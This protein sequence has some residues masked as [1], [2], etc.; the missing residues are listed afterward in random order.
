MCINR[1]LR[2]IGSCF[3]SSILC[4][5]ASQI[6]EINAQLEVLANSLE[7]ATAELT[8]ALAGNGDATED[9][10]VPPVPTFTTIEDCERA[11][12]PGSCGSGQAIYEQANLDPPADAVGWYM[13]IAFGEM[14]GVLVN[15]YY[16]P[17]T[18]YV[19]HVRYR[20][21]L[22]NTDRYRVLTPATAAHFRGASSAVQQSVMASGQPAR[23]TP[24]ARTGA[25]PTT[26]PGAT[27][28]ARPGATPT[29]RPGAASTAK[30]SAAPAAKSAPSK[31]KK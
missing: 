30:P 25:T 12:G 31:E 7:Q 21:Y 1:T 11:Y 24:A 28:T 14:T 17:P 8:Q 29:A 15:Q 26:R 19:S 10:L 18:V 22:S 16:A 9:D 20:G 27:P 6:R 13:P 23:V 5:C 3:L 4:G 2:F